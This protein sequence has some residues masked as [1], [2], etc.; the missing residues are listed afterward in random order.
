MVKNLPLRVQRIFVFLALVFGCKTADIKKIKKIDDSGKI[1]S[2]GLQLAEL[3]EGLVKEIFASAKRQDR[4]RL[5]T[6]MSENKEAIANDFFENKE[7]YKAILDNLDREGVITRTKADELQAQ[8]DQL[9]EMSSENTQKGGAKRIW[10]RIG[11]KVGADP[12]DAAMKKVAGDIY[13]VVADDLRT[14]GLVSF[15]ETVFKSVIP[16][17]ENGKNM[18]NMMFRYFDHNL[19]AP[20][21]VFQDTINK[22]LGVVEDATVSI[23]KDS[24]GKPIDFWQALLTTDRSGAYRLKLDEIAGKGLVKLMEESGP[25][26]T[27][28]LQ[29]YVEDMP[30][31]MQA[32]VR[33]VQSELPPMDPQVS[34]ERFKELDI[35][36]DKSKY[37]WP[38]AADEAKIREMIGSKEL[39]SYKQTNGGPTRFY[40]NLGTASLSDSKVLYLKNSANKIEEVV[41][42]FIKRE[43]VAR[44][45]QEIKFFNEPGRFTPGVKRALDLYINAIPGEL[46]LNDEIKNMERI[47]QG[48]YFTQQGV[49]L[50]NGKTLNFE[51][52][53]QPR[54]ISF[55]KNTG[56]IG[57]TGHAMIMNKAQGKPINKWV[58][59]RQS[60]VYEARDTLE[61]KYIKIPEGTNGYEISQNYSKNLGELREYQRQLSG[62]DY[63]D[64]NRKKLEADINTK[65]AELSDLSKELDEFFPNEVKALKRAMENLEDLETTVKGIYKQWMESAFNEGS[66]H[67][68]PHQGNIFIDFPKKGGPAKITLID[69]GGKVN[70]SPDVRFGFL[71]LLTA[72]HTKDYE[73]ALRALKEICS[74]KCR[75]ISGDLKQLD[76]KGDISILVGSDESPLDKIQKLLKATND[77]PMRF[78]QSF[79]DL[80]KAQAIMLKN[81]NSV[82]TKTVNATLSHNLLKK[83]IKGIDAVTKEIFLSE[84][85]KYQIS[86]TYLADAL[87][88]YSGKIFKLKNLS[89]PAIV[90]AAGLGTFFGDEVSLFGLAS[91]GS[92][93]SNSCVMD[94]GSYSVCVTYSDLKPSAYD[95]LERDCVEKKEGLW[96]KNS[97][98]CGGY[99]EEF[100]GCNVGLSTVSYAINQS[101]SS[102]EY[103]FAC[104]RLGELV[105]RPAVLN[106]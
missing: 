32:A 106:K 55:N 67:P 39:F 82:H 91:S 31:D 72:L 21:G 95:E 76:P 53:N 86:K 8:F 63:N 11:A 22:Q 100:F 34:A 105:G 1:N 97:H 5:V 14:K 96:L 66:F 52:V 90:T 4:N 38:D 37:S 30:P 43:A 85:F 12:F 92:S 64:P 101:P 51:V 29:S 70:I 77:T 88:V 10:T 69:V 16:N 57:G 73:K 78:D 35:K 3:H 75:H 27:K 59:I 47:K 94:D 103:E 68:D 7:K 71:N 19:A 99:G 93:G 87:N 50:G 44:Y 24:K 62:T 17:D 15:L 58:K 60:E 42:K 104:G 98:T 6:F 20:N 41:V 49:D 80:A 18:F 40:S 46:D 83:D 61:N 13:G 79:G 81:V 54:G 2:P 23:L 89:L 33:K 25:V 45:E 9:S 28:I 26:M 102:R 84:R 48:G 56:H 36:L 74:F 65:T